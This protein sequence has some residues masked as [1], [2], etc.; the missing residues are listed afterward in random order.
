MYYGYWLMC[1]CCALFQRKHLVQYQ[2]YQ[3]SKKLV[4][5][6]NGCSSNPN[7]SVR[8]FLTPATVSCKY[9]PNDS[10]QQRIT[11]ALTDL[12]AGNLLPFSLVESQEF[13]CFM[14]VVDSR[15]VIPSRKTL[16]TTLISDRKQFIE[17]K[18]R[19]TFNKL[20]T[21]SVTVD[22]WTNRIMHSF[23]GVTVHYIEDWNLRS[24]LLACKEFHGRHTG[25]N[26]VTHY[27]E[28]IEIFN[29]RNKIS[30]VISDSASNMIKAFEVTLPQFTVDS[31]VG[32][33]HQP[34]DEDSDEGSLDAI[35][36]EEDTTD[37]LL[38][39]I[40]E[41][42]ACFAH[43]LQLVIKD[44][45]KDCRQIENA[46]GKV[47]SIVSSIR[48]STAATEILHGYDQY[49]NVRA[50]NVT[51]WNSQWET[52]FPKRSPGGDTG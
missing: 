9:K 17:N 44:G 52:Y 43:T 3:G 47:A 33:K 41:R 29:L 8:A 42:L 25:E 1:C 46:I 11:V 38:S 49:H 20:D 39:C 31:E 51:R 45:I 34:N 26:I 48:R 35:G 18:L 7:G 14:D 15:Y 2:Q 5:A 24:G 4:K 37:H 30:H 13:R 10:R 6:D 36:L 12:I 16:S 19:T 22:I 28:L 27:D 21:V 32:D 50:A 23:L 40:P